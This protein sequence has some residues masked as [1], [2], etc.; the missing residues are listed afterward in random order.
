MHS[1]DGHLQLPCPARE[2]GCQTVHRTYVW[3]TGTGNYQLKNIRTI[4]PNQTQETW[5]VN[6][7]H[8]LLFNQTGMSSMT[9]C[10]LALIATHLRNL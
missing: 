6:H 5:L 9:G 3:P 2:N 4:S 10:W 1:T 8:K 7:H